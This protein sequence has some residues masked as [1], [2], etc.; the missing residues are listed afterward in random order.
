LRDKETAWQTTVCCAKPSA[1]SALDV[2]PPDPVVIEQ[3]TDFL[4]RVDRIAWRRCPV[5]G[6]EAMVVTAV[7]LRPGLLPPERAPP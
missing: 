5:C 7:I 1:R 4:R 3:I 6:A 2:R